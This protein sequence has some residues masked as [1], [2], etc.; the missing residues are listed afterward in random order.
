MFQAAPALPGLL[1]IKNETA[2]DKKKII[3]AFDIFIGAYHLHQL[4]LG[5]DAYDV[6][7][8]AGVQFSINVIYIKLN[9]IA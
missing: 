2:F 5:G 7:E 4:P 9:C 6:R 8:V 3:A 1:L